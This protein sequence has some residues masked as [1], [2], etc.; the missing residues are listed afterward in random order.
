LYTARGCPFNCVFCACSRY[1]GEVRYATAEYVIEEIRELIE[2]GVKVIRFS[3][4]NF[5]A[6]KERLQQIAE[7][8]VSNG[9]HKQVKFSCWCRSN[10]VTADAVKNLKAINVVSVKMGLESGCDRTLQYLKGNVTVKDNW[11]AI[12]LL[13]NAG[14]QVNG[15]FIIGAPDETEEEIM[16]TYEFIKSAPLDLVDINILSPLPGTPIWEYAV[17][18][19]LI[20]NDMNWGTLNFKFR[21]NGASSVIL[22]ERLTPRQLNRIHRKF[23]RLRLL[24][25]LKAL[26]GSPW[27]DE[28]PGMAFKLL[29]EKL[30][31]VAHSVRK[32]TA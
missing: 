15:D 8:V 4:D 1:W 20:T 11:N 3:D 30:L 21:N 25:I 12:M 9:F 13:K 2:N 16:L 29:K 31:M 32:D 14:I 22:S 27:L 5:V 19:K 6:N 17:E 7:M 28:L 10:S 24:K 23:A 18:R 26:P